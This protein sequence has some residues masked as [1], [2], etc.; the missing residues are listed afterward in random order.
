MVDPEST[1]RQYAIAI[2]NSPDD[3]SVL[4]KTLLE[5]GASLSSYTSP[6]LHSLLPN[7]TYHVSLF[8]TNG[9]N[10]E[11]VTT[12][13]PVYF[14][15]SPP[16]ISGR[17]LVRPNFKVADYIMGSLT[18]L[19]SGL[20]SAICL[21]DTDTVS[22]LFNTPLD[23]ESG[24]DFIYEI[25]IG[26]LPGSDDFV[27]FK[28]FDPMPMLFIS[29][30][31]LPSLYYHIHPLNFTNAA[32]RGVYFSVKIYNTARLYSTLVSNV[33]FISSNLTTERNWIYD[34]IDSRSDIDYQTSAIRIGASFHFGVNCPIRHGRWGVESVDGNL[35]QPY[36][37]I[38][39]NRFQDSLQNTF[40]VSSDQVLL[41]TNETYRVLVQAT[42]YTGKVHILRS[43]GVT[44]TTQGLIPGLVRDGPIPEQDLNYQESVSALWACWS[45]FGNGSPEQEIA[46]YEVTAGSNLE[47]PNT[48]SNIAP[49]TNVGLNT[50][51]VFRNLTLVPV[52]EKY[53]VTVRA[54]A[55]SGAFVESHSNGIVVGF[56]H[57]IVPGVITIPRYQADGTTLSA[58][59][60]DFESSL[61]IRQYEWALG[62]QDFS[63]NLLEEFCSNTNS[64]FS[65]RF[66]ISG[67]VN[68]GLDTYVRLSNL[69]L[70][71]NTTYY[72]TL[73]VLDQAKSCVSITTT[74]GLTI[75]QTPPT[76]DLA[77]ISVTLGPIQSRVSN[78]SFV[79][80]LPSGGDVT[81]EWIPFQD[82]ESGIEFYE[83][84]IFPESECGNE[85]SLGSAVVDFVRVDSSASLQNHFTDVAL[86][87]NMSYVAVVQAT[88][89]AGVTG[90]GY[91]QP[92]LLDPL[93]PFQGTIKD[94]TDWESDVTYQSDLSM[95]SAVFTHA[96]LP[97]S[98]PGVTINAPC[99]SASFFNLSMFDNAWEVPSSPVLTGYA[100][101]SIT[102][103][104]QQVSPSL[105][106]SGIRINA[107]RNQ[108]LPENSPAISGVYQTT[109]DLSNG[110]TFQADILA[111]VGVP[112][113][114][115]NA[116]TSLL[117]IDSGVVSNLIAKFEPDVRDFDFS[118]SPDF[119]A[120][121]VQIYRNFTNASTTIPQRV[122]MW[123][124][125][126]DTLGEPVFV[127]RDILDVDLSVSNTYR[128]E[129]Q[130][131]QLDFGFTRI[132]MLHINDVLV[133]SLHGLPLLSNSTRAVLHVFNLLG[134][135][136]PLALPYNDLSVYAVFA[137]VTLPSSNVPH[138]CDFGTPFHSRYSPI[139]EF[140][141]GVGS[142]TGLTDIQEFEVKKKLSSS[143]NY[144]YA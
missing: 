17:V 115:M 34:G 132:A 138:L 84:G 125:D 124:R 22:I 66:D 39:I 58:Y 65:E 73:R 25:G 26:F 72:L 5:G 89:G 20:E 113:F 97:P 112:E 117:F 67:F 140:R 94:G 9:A 78:S 126:S 134:Y 109:T 111:A 38:N 1:V 11:S 41:F 57:I 103:A 31:D 143:Y 59:W 144:H 14:D 19:T 92:I 50:T 119:S 127:S 71:D 102:Y 137:N 54:Y 37:D 53:Y 16:I 131:E 99:P 55:V 60:S 8:A 47:F 45:G 64:N 106:P 23:T 21:L 76:L 62:S 139:V 130:V 77:P 6:V 135:L 51:H 105:S 7:V 40:R 90:R 28:R 3:Q 142:R 30:G 27:K 63:S 80:Y 52:Q 133:S 56:G 116:V 104:R 24:R 108:M 93:P 70:H 13:S 33:V 42:D 120:F 12:S 101:S 49:Y 43:N 46:Y 88:N 81:V 74:E 75:D 18:N 35:T 82:Q 2:G 48:R 61:P 107:T 100:A 110:G 36:V 95:F 29:N 4:S 121:G 123:A 69:N 79:I 86:Q 114:Q 118:G 129:F 136:P 85:T 87:G 91:S 128:V 122:V 83:V 44:L 10:L 68:I 96:K 32:R 98:T 141:A 15:I